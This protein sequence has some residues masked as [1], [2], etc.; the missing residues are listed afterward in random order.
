ML[1]T[2]GREDNEVEFGI[3]SKRQSGK[4]YLICYKSCDWI[5][6]IGYSETQSGLEILERVVNAGRNMILGFIKRY[7]CQDL[8]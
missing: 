4:C 2:H 6:I 7:V 3:M 1:K 5:V 8:Q